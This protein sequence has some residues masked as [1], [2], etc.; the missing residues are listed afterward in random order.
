VFR[1]TRLITS[2][3]ICAALLFSSSSLS[4]ITAQTDEASRLP[5]QTGHTNAILEVRWSPNDKLLLTYSAADGF[6]NVWQMPQGKLLSTIEDSA[7]KVRGDDKRA[8]RAFAWSDDSR[9]I[10]TGS[11]NG[12]AQVWE[13]E[14]GKLLWSTRIADEYV[15]GVGF[16]GDGKYLAATAAP[17]DKKH[18]LVLLNGANGQPIKNLGEIESRFLT[19]YHD[20]KLVFSGDDKQLSVGDISGIITRWDLASGSLL[21]KKTLNLCSAERRM[22]NSFAYSEDLSLIVARCGLQSEVINTNSGA[23]CENSLSASI[24][25][26]PLL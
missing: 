23:I 11:E 26:A 10:A 6:L 8:L 15:T 1:K 17:E 9:L 7:V 18:K 12:T 22:P 16:S 4:R 24:S 13:A 21:S 2:A 14:T 5:L 3:L 25:P 19:Y 20:A